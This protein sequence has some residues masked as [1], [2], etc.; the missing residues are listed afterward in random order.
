MLTLK[1]WDKLVAFK[2]ANK[3]VSSQ[4]LMDFL[5]SE[6]L[7]RAP[8]Q[9]TFNRAKPG[10]F[11]GKARPAG[12][13]DPSDPLDI[14][15]SRKAEKKKGFKIRTKQESEQADRNSPMKGMDQ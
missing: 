4:Q 1:E 11:V 10:D 9:N 5:E 2:E 3:K 7:N 12:T 14:K 15:E 8:I 6:F 13:V